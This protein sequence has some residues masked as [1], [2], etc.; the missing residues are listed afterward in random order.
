[1]IIFDRSRRSTREQLVDGE[2]ALSVKLSG[3]SPAS[4]ETERVVVVLRRLPN[5]ELVYLAFVA[6]EKRFSEIQQI[7]KPV[8]SSFGVN[9]GVLSR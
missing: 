5:H 4:G 3:R 2:P 9:D 1:M 8:L 6:P 7:F